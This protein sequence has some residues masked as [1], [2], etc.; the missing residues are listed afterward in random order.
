MVTLMSR[1]DSLRVV[2]TAPQYKAYQSTLNM[3]IWQLQAVQQ[4]EHMQLN[5]L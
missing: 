1:E 5:L 4:V 2:Q 3:C